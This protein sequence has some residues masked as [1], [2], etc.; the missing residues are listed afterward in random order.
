MTDDTAAIQRAMDDG[1][2]CAPG[3]CNSSSITP[4]V[5]YFPAGTYVISSSIVDYYNTIMLGNPNS[6]PVLR[7][8]PGFTGFG[9]IDGDLYQPGGVLGFGG[10]SKV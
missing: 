9:L 6:L 2:R 7:A 4:A 10:K 1:N 5:V 3:Q 8:T